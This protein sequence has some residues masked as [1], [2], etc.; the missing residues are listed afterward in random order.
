MTRI[1][2]KAM[3]RKGDIHAGQED[4]EKIHISIWKQEK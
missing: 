2:K 4:E 3:T 1:N